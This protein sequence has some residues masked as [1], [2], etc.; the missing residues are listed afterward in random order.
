M[1]TWTFLLLLHFTI[2][3]D[4][5]VAKMGGAILASLKKMS[6]STKREELKLYVTKPK[7][8]ISKTLEYIKRIRFSF[9]LHVSNEWSFVAYLKGEVTHNACNGSKTV[10]KRNDTVHK[11][12]NAG[13][14]REKK[15]R[16][17]KVLDRGK[18]NENDRNGFV[19]TFRVLV[20]VLFW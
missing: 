4:T 10:I 5:S 16:K 1:I 6:F 17:E 2:L 12:V 9:G 3:Q 19:S 18:R 7:K 15:E 13:A 8:H 14:V 11:M 20:C